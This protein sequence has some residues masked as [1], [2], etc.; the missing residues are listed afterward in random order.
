M[1]RREKKGTSASSHLLSTYYN[2][3]TDCLEWYVYYPMKF[4]PMR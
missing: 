2:P 1:K 3:E 4:E